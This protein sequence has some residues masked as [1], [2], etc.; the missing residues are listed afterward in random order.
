MYP[1][2]DPPPCPCPWPRS[3]RI[4]HSISCVRD[5]PSPVY[6]APLHRPTKADAGPPTIC[7]VTPLRPMPFLKHWL[8]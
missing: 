8:A 1:K 7:V 4:R 3:P 6:F 2:R 5:S